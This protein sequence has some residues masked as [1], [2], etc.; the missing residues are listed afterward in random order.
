LENP[1]LVLNATEDLALTLAPAI[2]VSIQPTAP[3]MLT[4]AAPFA[5]EA[6]LSGFRTMFTVSAVWTCRAKIAGQ[7]AAPTEA[8]QPYLT[9]TE[10]P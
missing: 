1:P 10:S 5:S 8:E 6:F 2:E 3:E 7:A 4:H 9:A